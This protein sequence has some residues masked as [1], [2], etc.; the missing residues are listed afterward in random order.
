MDGSAFNPFHGFCLASGPSM[1]FGA[2]LNI[3]V[4]L[5]R[6]GW[7]GEGFPARRGFGNLEVCSLIWLLLM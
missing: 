5:S 1:F 2:E 6:L 4:A 3:T 7:G